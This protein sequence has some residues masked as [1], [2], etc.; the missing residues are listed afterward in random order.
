MVAQTGESP[1]YVLA[2]RRYA[3]SGDDRALA[4]F[5]HAEEVRE[6]INDYRDAAF[7]VG[8][9]V[10]AAAPMGTV[11]DEQLAETVMALDKSDPA[12]LA[13][14]SAVRELRAVQQRVGDLALTVYPEGEPWEQGV[15]DRL[16]ELADE[17]QMPFGEV[18]AARLYAIS[19]DETALRVMA[20]AYDGA[21]MTDVPQ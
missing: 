5:A 4:E 8:D 19:G 17:L 2:C 11:P 6:L 14:T 9:A 12:S 1:D 18:F 15:C 20:E 13:F 16:S 21:T 10:L 7:G 3:V